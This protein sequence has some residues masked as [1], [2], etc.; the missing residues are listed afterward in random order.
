MTAKRRA[1]KDESS[2]SRRRSRQ[3]KRQEKTNSR[4]TISNDRR[5]H[6]CANSGPKETKQ[7]TTKRQSGNAIKIAKVAI[8]KFY[9]PRRPQRDGKQKSELQSRRTI[10][11]PQD[12]ARDDPQRKQPTLACAAAGQRFCQPWQK[13]RQKRG[14]ADENTHHGRLTLVVNCLIS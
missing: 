11:M 6:E 2:W 3:P 10:L 7:T 9:L 13:P 4:Q 5:K 12:A 14:A 1:G 8:K